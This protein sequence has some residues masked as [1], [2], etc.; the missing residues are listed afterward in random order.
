MSKSLIKV[1]LLAPAGNFE[2]LK[3]ALQY[4]ADAIYLGGQAFGLRASAGNFSTEEIKKAVKYVH[5]LDKK[6][7]VTVNIFAHNYDLDR[8]PA[9][10]QELEQSNVD[11]IIVS[12]PGILWLVK[13]YI[14]NMEIHL[15]TQANT[16]NWAS[17]R[18]WKEQGISR[19]VL[20]R[21][22]SL[23]EIGKIADKNKDLE[24]ET[25][26]H[27]AM[28]MSYSGRCMLSSF[29]TGKSANR[30]ECTHP[31][32]WKY[33]LMEEKRPGEYM[34]IM[35]DERGTYIFNSRDLC[36]LEYIPELIKAGVCSFKIEGR[37]KSIHYVATIVKAYRQALD[38]YYQN[39]SEYNFQQ[40]WLQEVNKVS[41]RE[42]TTGFYFQRPMSQDYNY[43][44]GKIDRAYEFVGIVL[45]YDPVKRIALVQQRN[46]FSVGDIVEAFGP[47][48]EPVQ[49]VLTEIYNELNEVIDSAPHPL[50]LVSIKVDIPLEIN[51]MLRVKR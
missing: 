20:S 12:D 46:K 33:L 23:N 40:K 43:E 39:P 42:Y 32:R 44:E 13:K 51:A 10:L 8:L 38:S 11:A 21:E 16:T 17:C 19:V 34:P 2:K 24:L 29:L 31:C 9:Y 22:L 6:I 36:M 28:C 30:G 47:N 37:M 14:P 5:E 3:I 26:V 4:G 41:D 35:E 50:M 15:S 7:Y 25:F 45:G 1:E 48:T 18:F 49:F 27:G